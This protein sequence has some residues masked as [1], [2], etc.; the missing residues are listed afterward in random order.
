MR[1]PLLE[2]LRTHALAENFHLTI[3][4]QKHCWILN[5]LNWD[6][7]DEKLTTLG[8]QD[9]SIALRVF[10]EQQ[11][12]R[13]LQ[14]I[15]ETT[16]FKIKGSKILVQTE[17]KIRRDYSTSKVEENLFCLMATERFLDTEVLFDKLGVEG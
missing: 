14:F 8:R 7:L 16:R 12:K 5:R 11:K 10:I 13:P 9:C 17:A 3:I 1:H 15:A 6:E 2:K 4:W